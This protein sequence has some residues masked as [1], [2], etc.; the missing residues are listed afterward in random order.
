MHAGKLRCGLGIAASPTAP[1]DG[2]IGLSGK[3]EGEAI[4]TETTGPVRWIMS[5]SGE[6][7]RRRYGRRR[8]HDDGGG[9]MTMPRADANG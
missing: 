4:P 9:L 2:P 6:V 7:C 8:C 1:V 5:L 3:D